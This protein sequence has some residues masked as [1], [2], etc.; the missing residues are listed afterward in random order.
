MSLPCATVLGCKAPAAFVAAK[1]EV[2]RVAPFSIMSPV[3]GEHQ[4]L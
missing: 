1:M 2:K 4:D 3:H